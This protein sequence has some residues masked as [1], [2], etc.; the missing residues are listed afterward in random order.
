MSGRQQVSICMA[1]YNGARYLRPQLASILQQM[2][3]GD[4]L[5]VVDD[6]SQDDTLDIVRAYGDPRIRVYANAVNLGHVRT[7]SRALQLAGRPWMVLADQDD[8][9]AEGRLASLRA[10]LAR[11]GVWLATGNARFID[12]A[13]TA[14][15]PAYRD[16]EAADSGRHALNILRIFT[17]RAFYYG[18]NMAF[19]QEL[20]RLALPIPG[21][22]E[23]HDLWLAMAA[24]LAG[25][26]LHLG[27]V[28]LYRRIHGG[29]V[30][31]S[32]RPLW[33]KLRSRV[34]FLRALAHLAWRRFGRRA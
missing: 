22:V 17:G 3:E 32:R 4:E 10:A 30:T 7:F 33:R 8:I 11:P 2:E 13:G 21:Y 1:T 27:E 25:R 28:L 26:N 29:N 14:I 31:S 12:A 23:S 18:C 19:S 9:W 34:L 24:N 16:L 20:A 15:P 6:A 5:I